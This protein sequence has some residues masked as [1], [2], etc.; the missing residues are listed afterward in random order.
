MCVLLKYIT[1]IK[2]N[3]RK[4]FLR[5]WFDGTQPVPL[6]KRSFIRAFILS[7]PFSLQCSHSPR[8]LRP[9]SLT[10]SLRR[11][12]IQRSVHAIFT[13]LSWC[14]VEY[15]S[16]VRSISCVVHS[17]VVHSTRF[18][19]WNWATCHVEHATLTHI[20][21]TQ[22]S[23]TSR[24]LIIRFECVKCTTREPPATDSFRLPTSLALHCRVYCL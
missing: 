2:L 21:F 3:F 7:Y 9:F 19:Q 14:F 13:S 6:T 10:F 17:C 15:T 22:E 16:N 11:L 12:R 8:L 23:N 5:N 20:R 4:V 24:Y 18:I 1:E